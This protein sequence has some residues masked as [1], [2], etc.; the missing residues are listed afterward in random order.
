MDRLNFAQT[1]PKIQRGLNGFENLGG[2]GVDVVWGLKIF[3]VSKGHK[4]TQFCLDPCYLTELVIWVKPKV[5]AQN[6]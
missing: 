2:E 6:I 1:S 3:Q 5:H 4:E